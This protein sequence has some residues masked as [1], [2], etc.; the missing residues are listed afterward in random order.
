[1]PLAVLPETPIHR[2]TNGSA[3][4]KLAPTPMNKDCMTKPVVRCL[5]SSLSAT[6]ARK[7]SMEMLID[8]SSTHR[9]LAAIQSDDDVGMKNSAI[10]ARIA[11]V[12]KYGRR[13]PSGPHVR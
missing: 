1:M 5:T 11:P 4:A 2:S 13:R 8:A 6:N 7:G 12:K 3:F 10:E 9:R